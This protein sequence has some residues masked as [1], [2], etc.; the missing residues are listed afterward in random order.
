MTALFNT[1]VGQILA[2]ALLLGLLFGP[3]AALWLA[4][5]IRRSLARIA[6]TLESN[7]V[8]HTATFEDFEAIPQGA[9]A[10][11]ERRIA[12]SIFGR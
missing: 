2:L 9:V 7:E 6:D 10:Q 11:R 5:S 12:N 8:R 1:L 3:L 4:L